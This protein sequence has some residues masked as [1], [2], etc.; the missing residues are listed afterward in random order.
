MFITS[1]KAIRTRAA[2]QAARLLARI[3]R[4][5]VDED[6]DRQRRQRAR[7]RRTEIAFAAI[8]VVKR[9]GAVS[10][11]TRAT[12]MTTPVRMPPIAAGRTMF[13]VVRH[14]VT[15]SARL[16]CAQ[17]LRNDLEDLLRRASDHREHQDRERERTVDRALP[18]S[19][20]EQAEDEDA[21]HDRGDAVQDVEHDP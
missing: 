5:R 7:G 1:T 10:P 3:R 2:A 20:D 11:A 17:A 16:A 19:D 14:L 12:A 15:P 6:R 21:D 4:L 13:H 9:S 8:D 18:V